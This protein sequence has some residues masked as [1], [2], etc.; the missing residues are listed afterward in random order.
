[1]SVAK[2]STQTLVGHLLVFAQ[3]LVLTPLIIKVAGTETYAW[4]VLLASY[5]SI[6]VGISS[7]GVGINAKRWFLVIM[8]LPPERHFFCRNLHFS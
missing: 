7:F 3:G 6:M 1:M 4:Y 8:H 2:K 5:L